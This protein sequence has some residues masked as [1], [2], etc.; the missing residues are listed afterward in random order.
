MN[1]MID[2]AMHPLTR[3]DLTFWAVD[4]ILHGLVEQNP[5]VSLKKFVKYNVPKII[6]QL[7]NQRPDRKPRNKR[8]K[9]LIWPNL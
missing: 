7:T 6:L 4:G 3:N 9:I 1:K 5:E 8:K 2:A